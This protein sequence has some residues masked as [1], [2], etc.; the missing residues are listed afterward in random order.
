[1]QSLSQGEIVFAYFPYEEDKTLKKERPC[2]VL[3]VDDTNQKFLVAKITTT[4]IERY[5]VIHL[6]AGTENMAKGY[7]IRTDSWINLN[8]REWISYDDF[9]FYIGKVT[10]FILEEIFIKIKQ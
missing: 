6:K 1:M 4:K 7:L 8:R 5:W 3:A 2:L 9:I 10:D